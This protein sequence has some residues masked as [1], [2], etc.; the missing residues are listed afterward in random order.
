MSRIALVL[1]VM[2]GAGGCGGDNVRERPT[3]PCLRFTSCGECTPVRGCGWCARP[4]AGAVCLSDPLSCPGPQFTWTWESVACVAEKDAG[5]TL[6]D[7]GAPADAA[8]A[9]DGGAMCRVPA[10][11]NTFVGSDAGATGCLPSTGG[12]LCGAG[13][14]TLACHGGGPIPAP[15]GALKCTIV[16]IPTP[17]NVLFHCCPCS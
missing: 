17:P 5:A 6:A 3:D 15:D 1:L 2:I 13:Q 8:A 10:A 4:D 16:P 14:Y 11:A 12:N 7:A 9:D